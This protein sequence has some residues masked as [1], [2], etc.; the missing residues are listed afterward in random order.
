MGMVAA[1]AGR[2]SRRCQMG[3]IVAE[4]LWSAPS[5]RAA[6]DRNDCWNKILDLRQLG[7]YIARAINIPR[8]GGACI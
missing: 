6:Y 1:H 3:G 2:Y 7:L 4:Q 5:A 8:G